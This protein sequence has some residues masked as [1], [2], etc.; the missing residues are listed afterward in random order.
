MVSV[1]VFYLWL[2]FH[3]Y[4]KT[5]YLPLTFSRFTGILFLYLHFK[6]VVY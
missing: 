2:A 5:S 6:K 4:A 1:T 3:V